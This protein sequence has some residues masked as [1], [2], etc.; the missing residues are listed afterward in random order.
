MK[1][2]SFS[3]VFNLPNFTARVSGSKVTIALLELSFA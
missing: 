1:I 2:T 3:I